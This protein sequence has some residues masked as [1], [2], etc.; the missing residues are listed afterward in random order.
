MDKKWG[1]LSVD[2]KREQRLTRWLAPEGVTFKDGA[3]AGLYR[4]RIQ[5]LVDVMQLKVPDRVPV[6]LDL[7]MFPARYAGISPQTAMYDYERLIQAWIKAAMDFDIDTFYSPS[8]VPSGPAL[9]IM[10][11]RMYK[12]PGH[13]VSPG[14]GYQ[15]QEAEYMT[16]DE[17]DDLIRDHSDFWLRK[18][19]PRVFGTWEPLE[20]LPALT[21]FVEIPFTTSGLAPF[22]LPGVKG[23]LLSLIKAGEE[24][25]QWEAAIARARRWSLES[26]LPSYSG[27]MAKAPFDTIG[28]TLRGTQGIIMD[29]YRQPEKLLEAVERFIPIEIKRGV[30]AS[31]ASGVPV[32]VM[33]LHKGADG[34]M[35][36]AQ[37]KKFYWPSLKKVILALIDEGI[38]PLLFAEGGYNSRLEVVQELPA[39]RVVWHFDQTDM[40]KAKEILGG[41]ACLMGNVP[42]SV[43]FSASISEV[44]AHC[45]HLIETAGK[46]GGFILAN[47]AVLDDGNPETLRA[48][49]EAARESGTY[50]KQAL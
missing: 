17:Y 50:R 3:A 19:L 43:L 49:I 41:R 10:D 27:G 48:L 46:N 25:R 30:T 24:A 14:Q 31:N 11:Y 5:R 21:N 18:Y 2:E 34:F 42:S 45:Q 39:G 1:D 33:P 16:A 22:G 23:A 4:D 13:G 15:Y 29:M 9:E 20:K 32:V 28:D 36:A 40:Q 8:M 44:K 47:G 6:V 12:W 7:G 26:G 38:T 37:F 35:S